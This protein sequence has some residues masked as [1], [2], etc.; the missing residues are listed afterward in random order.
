MAGKCVPLSVRLSKNVVKDERGCW[1]YPSHRPDGR[2]QTSV[3][4]VSVYVYRAVFE[5]YHRPLVDGE[6]V[7]H[8]CDNPSCVNPEHLFAG[9]NNDNRQ[10]S[11]KK[12][13]HARGVTC[14]HS[15]VTEEQ[16]IGFFRSYASG[17]SV[18]SLAARSGI[19]V[20]SVYKVLEGRNWKHIQMD[21]G[22]RRGNCKLLPGQ[23]EEVLTKLRQGVLQRVIAE[24]YGIT[25]SQVS[26]IRRKSKCD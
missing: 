7:C 20:R 3:N 15:R 24:E 1:N 17:E 11:V 14:G 18:R 8:S 25:Q 16:A 19:S 23:K 10:D 9:S 4:G 13:R 21:T 5:Q 22:P 6:H 2:P 12:G 26:N